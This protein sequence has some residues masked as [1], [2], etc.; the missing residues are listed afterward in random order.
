VYAAEI[1]PTS[2]LTLN[3]AEAVST[4]HNL[5]AHLSPIEAKSREGF[6]FRIDLQVQIHV[7]DTRAPKVISMVGTMQNL[8]NEVLQAAVGNHFR[9]TL[10]GLEAVRFIETRAEVQASAL[11]AI[12]TY[13]AAYDVE[14]RG[15]YIQDVDFPDELVV[16][17]TKREIANQE[18]ATYAEQER[19]EVVR[20]EM[21]KARGTADM[22]AQLAQ[23][24][25]GIGIR[26]NEAQAREAQA[27]GEAAYV[28]LTGRAEAAKTEAIGLAE[29]KA[30]EALGLARAAGFQAQTQALGQTATALVAVAN[31]VAEGKITVVPEV[32]VAGGGG[33]I[34][35]L[36][37]TLMRTLGTNGN[38]QA[39][40]PKPVEPPA[41]PAPEMPAS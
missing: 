33:A 39:P 36:A 21:E 5:D 13:L 19:A 27:R 15:V 16:V 11:A 30:T 32:L 35:G 37:A 1:V 23:S 28:E 2:I 31:A 38:G 22:Q 12:T 7:P 34:E 9:N 18:K 10:Q 14:T 20:I 3:W 40:K 41:P 25:V 24:A 4:A 29:A 8:V 6:V 26:D 17:L